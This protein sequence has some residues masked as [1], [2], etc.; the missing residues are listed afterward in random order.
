MI[1]FYT[2]I[3]GFN[4][5][6]VFITAFV[7]LIAACTDE[8]L[9]INDLKKI[10]EDVNKKCPQMI[11][12]ETRLDGINVEE[13]NTLVYNYTLVNAE[14]SDADTHQFYLSMWPGLIS[15]IKVSKEMQKLRDNQTIIH[16]M[17]KNKYNKIFYRF[18]IYPKDY[19][20]N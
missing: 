13:P 12:S 11:D 3:L 2:H 16:Y 1:N 9:F 5:K 17:Y 20:L 4:F 14:V 18:K 8:Q 15:Y 7:F 10:S 6:W 19:N